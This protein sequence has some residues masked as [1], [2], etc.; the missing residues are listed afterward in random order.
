MD[1]AVVSSRA[2]LLP[3][4]P[5]TVMMKP[6]RLRL[7]DGRLRF[8]S[9]DHELILDAPLGELH[10]ASQAAIG[11]H[12]WHGQKR[13]R[14]AVGN[15]DRHAGPVDDVKLLASTWVA[16]LET[17]I[18]TAPPGLTI[19]KPWPRWGWLVGVLALSVFFV[20]A[21]VIVVRLKS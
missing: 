18:G 13:Y 4:V 10:S 17:R 16:A 7:A 3:A 19:R 1:S 5:F 12:V 9:K 14:F 6:G 11:I 15:R 21:V 8:T 2:D 20:A